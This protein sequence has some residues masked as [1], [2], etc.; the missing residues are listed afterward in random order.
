MTH[1]SSK[2]ATGTNFLFSVY[3]IGTLLFIKV[4]FYPGVT[5]NH[6]VVAFFETNVLKKVCILNYPHNNSKMLLRLAPI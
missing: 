3:V 6:H 5:F 1:K 4:C 2:V